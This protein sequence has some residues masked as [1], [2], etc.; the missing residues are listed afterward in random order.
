MTIQ[1]YD[2]YLLLPALLSATA[3]VWSRWRQG[4]PDG[5]RRTALAVAGA[6]A[7][8]G[9]AVLPLVLL[10]LASPD[11]FLLNPEIIRSQ[12]LSD[13]AR[14]HV[15]PA[16]LLLERRSVR[17]DAARGAGGLRPRAPGPPRPRRSASRCSPPSRSAS[18]CSPAPRPG[19]RACRS[20]RGASPRPTRSSFSACASRPRPCC[21]APGCSASPPS[22]SSSLQN[23]LFSAAGAARSRRRRRR[24]ELPHRRSGVGGRFPPDA[25]T[26]RLLAGELGLRLE[27]RSV[28]RA[29]RRPLRPRAETPLGAEDRLARRRGRP[30]ARVVPGRGGRR[31]GA[32][33]RARTPRSS[34]RS[35]PPSTGGCACGAR[36]PGT[37]A[38]AHSRCGSR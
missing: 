28:P 7:A 22:P 33:P 8:F 19:R 11:R 31:P 30:R 20:G 26:P 18:T 1:R 37:P 9:L 32:G 34:S 5:R 25:G 36:P 16:A 10:T 23:V 35:P 2:A 29:L 21:G 13:W 4:D 14:P 27:T 6:G 38:R 3:L 17:V 24:G 12:M 15:G